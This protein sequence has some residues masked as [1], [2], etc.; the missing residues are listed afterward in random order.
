M[1]SLAQTLTVSVFCY[2]CG[3]SCSIWRV[4]YS[5]NSRIASVHAREIFGWLDRISVILL[6]VLPPLGLVISEYRFWVFRNSCDRSAQNSVYSVQV[7]K[8]SLW[9]GYTN[10]HLEIE[11]L[12]TRFGV[13]WNVFFSAYIWTWT[14]DRWALG[15]LYF[16]VFESWSI[17][18]I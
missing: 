15:Q 13:T 16:Q 17:S 8:V 10:T 2:C 1:L 11:H 18:K 6:L 7:N 9:T 3:C 4:G 14:V 12:Q 5:S